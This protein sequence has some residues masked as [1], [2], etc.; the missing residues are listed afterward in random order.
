MTHHRS[1]PP[2]YEDLRASPAA[3]LLKLSLSELDTFIARASKDARD[4]Q[5]LKDWLIWLK[6]EKLIREETTDSY[7]GGAS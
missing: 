4:A 2:R 1:P 3:D 7:E 5:A 6:A